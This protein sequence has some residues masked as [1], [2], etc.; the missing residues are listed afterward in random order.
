MPTITFDKDKLNINILD[1]IVESELALSKS[2]A[3]RLVEQ[4]GISLNGKKENNIN[5]IIS[6][7]D[8]D[9]DFIIVKKGKKTFLKIKFL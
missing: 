5:K 1:L 3:R 8:L 6:K 7:I 9:N 4:N 2:E